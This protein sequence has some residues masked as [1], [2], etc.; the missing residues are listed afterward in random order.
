[1]NERGNILTHWITVFLGALYGVTFEQWVSLFVLLVGLFTAVVNAYYKRRE[2][3]RKDEL[4]RLKIQ[5]QTK[6]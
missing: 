6:T 4:H 5:A 1:M 3:A 2:D